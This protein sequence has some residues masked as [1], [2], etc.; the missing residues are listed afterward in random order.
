VQ[1]ALGADA[2]E[3]LPFGRV[4]EEL[5]PPRDLSRQPL[6][7][8]MFQLQNAPVPPVELPGVILGRV[9]PEDSETAKFDVG[10]FLA[11]SGDGLVGPLEYSTDLFDRSTMERLLR[12]Y[13]TLLAEIV[14]DPGRRL[15]E[16]PLLAPA[17]LHQLLA[18]WNDTAAPE[19]REVGIHEL[20]EA[21][22]ERTPD[23]VAVVLSAPASGRSER[24]VSYRELDR[25]SNRLAHCLRQLGVG[26]DVTVGITLER[27][28]DLVEALL[29]I[30]KAGGIFVPLD[31]S[32]PEARLA[33]MLED[34]GVDLL[35]AHRERDELPPYAGR[36]L[37]LDAEREVIARYSDERLSSGLRPDHLA[38]VVYTSGSTGRPKGVS[39]PHRAL[40]NLIHW[41]L[42]RA[43]FAR[44][45]RTL[46]FTSM[47]FDVFMQ[48]IF[49]TLASGGSLFLISE[50]V[51][52]DPSRIAEILEAAAIERLFLPF[53]AL[54]QL[55]EAAGERPP[56]ALRE[57]I[58]AGEQLQISPQVERFFTQLDERGG[59]GALDNQYGPSES[60]VVSAHALVGAAAGWPALPPIG[61]A[62]G[63]FRIYL[64][65][66]HLRPVPAG[67]AGE[68]FLSG[69]G[70]ARGYYHRPA[71]TAEK[72]LP[73]PLSGDLYGEE[74]GARMYATGD[75][76]RYRADGEIEFLGRI[77]H[78]VKIRGYRIELGEIEAVLDRSPGVRECVVTARRT[79]PGDAGPLR[80]AAYVVAAPEPSPAVRELRSFLQEKLPDY[81]VPAAFVFVDALPL[82]PSGKVDRRALPA[83]QW[84]HGEMSDLVA[85]RT[86]VEELLAGVWAEVLGLD[87]V[88]VDDNFFEL[89][90]HS[91]LA[92][93][94]ASRVREAFG[95]EL[96]LRRLF[97]TPTV[98][99][100][101]L[102]IQEVW[103]QAKGVES[104]PIR[105]VPR[106]RELPLSF[107]Q[108]RLWFLDQL[109]PGTAVYNIP[110]ALRLSGTVDV[111]L[112]QS[113]FHEIL[114]R[115]EALRTTFGVT[116]GRAAYGG[117]VQVIAEDLRLPLPVV[118]LGT[119][120]EPARE[121]ETRRRAAAEARRPFDLAAGPLIRVTLL[122]L[123]QEDHVALVTM[124]HIVTDGWSMA[125]FV[126]ELSA[127]YGAFS[128]G[129][130]AS[131]LAELPVQYADFAYW[132][133]QWLEG[134]VLERELAY[135]KQQ[136]GTAPQRLEL[137]CDRPRPAVQ[138]FRG[139]LWPAALPRD[140][141]A[142]LAALA[143]RQGVTSFM[144]L[145]AGF[146]A[147][148]ARHT[149]QDEVS[150]GSPIAGRNRK[151]IEGLI[152][153]FVNTL[154]LRAD[155]SRDPS[156][157]ELLAQVRQVALDGYAHQN[158]P[159]ERL[160]E[161]LQPQ[162]DLSTTPLFQVM[163]VLQNTP[164]EA[165]GLPGMRLRPV[166]TQGAGIAKFELTLSLEESAAGIH[167]GIEYNVD[168]FDDSTMA[169]LL[170]HFERLLE[171]AVDDPDTRLSE[172]PWLSPGEEHQLLVDWDEAGGAAVAARSIH[173]LFEARAERIPDAV[174]VVAA[175]GRLSYGE[176]DRRADQLASSL[177]GLGVRPEVRVGICL[178][179][180]AQLVVALLGVL[181]AGGAYV[182]LDPAYPAERL[183]LLLEDADVE[184]LLTQEAL[185][186]RL[187]ERETLAV[188]TLCLDRERSTIG[189][190][191][192]ARPGPAARPDHLAYVIYTSGS[193]GRPKGVAIAHRSAVAMLEWARE[194]F[195]AAELGGVLASTSICF[196]L[197][198]FEL[199]APLAWGGRVILARDALE[200]PALPAAAEVRLV[201]TVPSAITEL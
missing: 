96:A 130:S 100:L 166:A 162:R 62:V 60:H 44:G 142:A 61:R 32:Y 80:L 103:E 41:Q 145:L 13:R 128:L 64:L 59:G 69:A 85:P 52:R 196:D 97:E 28:I 24:R 27:S 101:A 126:R 48:E 172:L 197:S 40:T 3:D 190:E 156:F 35:L 109:E 181:K 147:L 106:D 87:Q 11:R 170:A 191:R 98:A 150:V 151:E 33:F 133:R 76:G 193:T 198:V 39:M 175:G 37:R 6:F 7:Q 121:A 167:G 185:I 118:D 57:V 67:V 173:G 119:L 104:A 91:L 51:R 66:A 71:L 148:L 19:S 70:L 12:Q 124:H 183:T 9:P 125:I 1:V 46:Q 177:R 14:A 200:L 112:L 21:R 171:G 15:C 79:S 146:Q 174:A 161:E 113:I 63:N 42:A 159:F 132:Q 36:I 65:D 176:L 88:G 81:M 94:V 43:G 199:F 140:L 120:E 29:G 110:S 45:S 117:P 157:R 153:F 180:S 16:L 137:P 168:L 136:L 134:E 54:Q 149:G 192:R 108:Q 179:R 68:V 30:L 95:V 18:E 47:S 26:P 164:R 160:V 141:S 105:P 73:D 2:D 78:Q 90:G 82:L 50:E 77:D 195:S 107:A 89:G 129:R 152:G 38:Y 154:V 4:V 184:L 115:H 114:R 158:L 86:Q 22:V 194:V 31:R 169:R 155:L 131:G 123:A 165:L 72:F 10:F 122:R 56:A 116:A 135:W 34:A 111:E 188:R 55:A 163:F 127:L 17:E 58:T 20:F 186:E 8:V 143:R 93:Q 74:P 23:A 139:S 201:N 84:R 99:G 53:V 138:S 182:P 5:R 102:S 83:P 189:A 75:L 144:T 49:S 187:P 92:T 25:R 178:E